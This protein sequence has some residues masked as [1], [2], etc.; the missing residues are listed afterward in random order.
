[1]NTSA[2]FPPAQLSEALRHVPLFAGLPSESV[3]CFELVSCG[4][5]RCF[6]EG[7]LLR[8]ASE[9]PDLTI[10]VNGTARVEGAEPVQ[11][12]S[13]TTSVP[14]RYCLIVRVWQ[15]SSGSSR[16]WSFGYQPKSLSACLPA[17]ACSH[18][19]S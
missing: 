3:K 4:V 13:G 1:M 2:T 6:A 17:V 19:S 10:V 8:D 9:P 16:A 11:L 15:G 14:S 5:L 7:E 18:G 12:K